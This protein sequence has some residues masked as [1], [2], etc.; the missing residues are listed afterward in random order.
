MFALVRLLVPHRYK[1]YVDRLVGG[2]VLG[3]LVG[4]FASAAAFSWVG[5]NAW[6]VVFPTTFAAAVGGAAIAWRTRP[7]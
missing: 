3:M 6:M 4:F 5:A 1:R 2:V 7:R